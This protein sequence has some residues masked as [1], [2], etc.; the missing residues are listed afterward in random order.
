MRGDG[1]AGPD[2]ESGESRKAGVNDRRELKSRRVVSDP[3]QVKL[4]TWVTE[5]VEVAGP[6]SHD[7]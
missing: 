2:A 4:E 6:R 1:F 3:A 5:T 7:E